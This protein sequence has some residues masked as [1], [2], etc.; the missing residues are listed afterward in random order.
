MFQLV[1]NPILDMIKDNP[2]IYSNLDLP[3][4]V[5]KNKKT[6]ISIIN[7]KDCTEFGI[8]TAFSRN[9]KSYTTQ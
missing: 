6:G 9:C 8:G 5:E 3:S 7:G 4:I 1:V 2:S